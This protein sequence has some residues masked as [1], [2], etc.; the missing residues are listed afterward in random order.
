MSR[1]RL[2]VLLDEDIDLSSASSSWWRI[3]NCLKNQ[4]IYQ[5]NGRIAI[6]ATGVNPSSLVV[7]DRQTQGLL[8][9]RRDEYS[10]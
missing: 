1:S 7:E 8:E 4:S 9:R 10:S 5:D 2:L 3:I 6:D